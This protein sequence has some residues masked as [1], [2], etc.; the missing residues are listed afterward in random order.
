MSGEDNEDFTPDTKGARYDNEDHTPDTEGARYV[1]REV[2]VGASSWSI[3]LPSG[4]LPRR[5]RRR[6]VMTWSRRRFQPVV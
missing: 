4:S 3:V 2:E 6:P 5:S 1:R